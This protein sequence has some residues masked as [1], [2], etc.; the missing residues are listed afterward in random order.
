MTGTGGSS[1]L[2]VP[3]DVPPTRV[4]FFQI[5]GLAMGILYG[6]LSPGKGMLFGN[7]GQRKVKILLIVV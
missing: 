1:I 6:N 3:R 5:S 2:K 4:Y 7:F